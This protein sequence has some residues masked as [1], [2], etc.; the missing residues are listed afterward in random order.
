MKLGSP[1]WTRDRGTQHA[2]KWSAIPNN[3]KTF[4]AQKYGDKVMIRD[5]FDH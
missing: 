5:A 4:K 2:I 1:L 3:K